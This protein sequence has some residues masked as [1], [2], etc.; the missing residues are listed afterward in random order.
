MKYFN[1]ALIE[2]IKKKNKFEGYTLTEIKTVEKNYGIKFPEAYIEFLNLM[3]KNVTF[4]EVYII[5]C[6][7]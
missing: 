5:Q 4:F 1:T 7:N 6:T 3:G 2:E